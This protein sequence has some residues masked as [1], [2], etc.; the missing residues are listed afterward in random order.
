[1]GNL[2]KID[3][4]PEAKYLREMTKRLHKEKSEPLTLNQKVFYVL[5]IQNPYLQRVEGVK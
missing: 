4:S 1:M 5:Q 3:F 2:I